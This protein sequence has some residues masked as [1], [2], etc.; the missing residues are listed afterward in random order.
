MR[1]ARVNPVVLH[2]REQRLNLSGQWDFRLDPD[3]RGLEERWFQPGVILGDGCHVPG[4]WQGQ[5]HGGDGKDLI[6]DFRLQARTLRA[7]YTGTGW[8]GRWFTIPDSWEG[9]R[10]WLNFG[11]VHP[12]AQVWLNGEPLGENGMPFVPF[13]FDIT[14]LAHSGEPNWVAVRVHEANRLLGLAYSFQGNWSGLYRDVE[15]TATG[16][17]FLERLWV[18]GDVP[19]NVLR[20]RMMVGGE[21]GPEPPALAVQIAPLPEG[22]TVAGEEFL[23]TPE[24][25]NPR[26]GMWELNLPVPEPRL[27]SPDS[28]ALYRV[29]VVLRQGDEV[30]DAVSER[31]GFVHLHTEGKHFCINGEPY[32]MRGTG[33]FLSNPET[34]S[35]DTDRDRWRRKLQ[36]LR[37]YGYNYV[38]CQSY[39]YGPEYYD[40]ADEV[41]LLVQ[42][43]MGMLGAWGGHDAWHVYQWPKPTPAYRAALKQQWDAVVMRDVNHPSANLYCMSNEYG[44]NTDFPR[45]A[46]QCYHDTRAIKPTALVIWTDGGHN[47]N[48][49]QDFVNADASLDAQCDKPV[50]QHEYQWWSSFPDVRLMHK[51]TGAQ[52]PF[53]QE[54]ALEAAARHGISHVLPKAALCSQ[55]L[56]LAES[57]AKMERC[58][59]DNPRLAGICH[60]NAM[61]ANPS[62]QGVIDEFYEHKLATAD[63]W[64][65]TNGDTV[66]LS[67][68][69]FADRVLT[70]GSRVTVRLFVSDFSHPPFVQPVLEWHLKAGGETLGSGQ[71]AYPHTPFCT[72][73]AGQVGLGVPEVECPRTAHLH[74][75]LREADRAV[76]NQWSLW[77][78]PAQTPAW[79]SGVAIHGRPQYTWLARLA[80]VPAVAAEELRYGRQSVALS[81]RLDESLV[82]FMRAGGRVLLA[83]SEGLVRPYPPKFGFTEGHYYFTPPANYPPY[84]DGHDGHI[85][86]NHPLLGDFPHEGWA[87]WQL[88]NLLAQSPPLDLEPLGLAE[89]D[90]VIRVMHSYPV[91]RPL[92]YLVERRLGAGGL[93]ISALGLDPAYPEARYLLAQ[94]LTFIAGP[95]FSPPLELSPEA[96][97]Q[98]MAGTALP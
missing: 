79:P 11:G 76:T 85:I 72:C 24:G 38:R 13:G 25:Q 70:G 48:L 73:A 65:Q 16:S 49:P 14:D 58:R 94:M 66:V 4:C 90:P 22:D 63:M 27:W 82:A 8:Y 59:R 6:W 95:D 86:A 20:L 64:L 46:W 67:S 17:P 12:S 92:G 39:V 56:Q 1:P 47:D 28:P 7:T 45:I 81:E 36:T 68:L 21:F 91:C 78:L 80:D 51:Y 2:P 19:G 71:V 96:L 97:E 30:L 50:I 52:R 83:A 31:T 42:S 62:P 3:D 35:P 77:L 40:V 55:R 29:D 53:A 5:G 37:A 9:R 34:V 57:K 98:L 89:G 26:T 75:T 10:L 44:A 41:G 18:V 87:D 23:L 69:G 15:L 54:I 93:V 74:V 33:D 84:E 60:F 61:D 32:Y 88:F 43:E